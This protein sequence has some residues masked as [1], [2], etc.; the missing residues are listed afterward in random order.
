MNFHESVGITLVVCL[1]HLMQD[2]G[3]LLS[4][5]YHVKDSVTWQGRVL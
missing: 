1:N 5:V 3:F 4:V 2:F